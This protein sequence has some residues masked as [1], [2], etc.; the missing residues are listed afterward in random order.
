M[1]VDIPECL[2]NGGEAKAVLWVGRSDGGTP[3]SRSICDLVSYQ[4]IQHVSFFLT[5]I[6]SGQSTR[7]QHSVMVGENRLLGIACSCGFTVSEAP[8][9]SKPAD[10]RVG[11]IT[12]IEV[13]ACTPD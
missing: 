3:F 1:V 13:Y 11:C 2:G 12:C 10:Y 4:S 8:D 5:Y 6:E 9:T 7:I